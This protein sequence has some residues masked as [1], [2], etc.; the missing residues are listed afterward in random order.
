MNRKRFSL[1]RRA[2]EQEPL[3]AV[4]ALQ[5]NPDH[6][7]RVLSLV[8]EWIRHSDAKAGVTL[9]FT[10]ALGAM[11]F[12]L[13]AGSTVRSVVFDTFIVVSSIFLLLTAALCGWTLT[14]RMSDRYANPASTN[15][16]FFG[17][18]SKHFAGDR[19][20][21]TEALSAM[22]SDP[23]ELLKD[24][25]DQIHANALI[26]TLKVRYAKLAIRSALMSAAC[27][28]IVALI[29]GVDGF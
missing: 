27:V 15:R 23:K 26:A 1:G 12:K 5:P 8:N 21:Y 9:A 7:W 3:C 18:I 10:G 20:R 16:L 6:A 29:V 11:L 4:G 2:R 28:A 14:P 13:A 19:V 25:A 22:T 24:L 17:S